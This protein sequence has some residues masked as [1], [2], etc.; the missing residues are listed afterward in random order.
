MDILE[1]DVS[2]TIKGSVAAGLHFLFVSIPAGDVEADPIAVV[3]DAEEG[4]RLESFDA[5]SF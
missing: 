4:V 1:V 2:P 3:L 5:G